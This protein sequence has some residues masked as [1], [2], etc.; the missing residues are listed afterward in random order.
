LSLLDH[1]ASYVVIGK[2]ALW[3]KV[4]EA[5]DGFRARFAKIVS[6][7][8]YEES[9]EMAEAAAQRYGV[10]VSR[11]LLR[12]PSRD[13]PMLVG[14][15]L[16]GG[17]TLIPP[18]AVWLSDSKVGLPCGPYDVW[19]WRGLDPAIKAARRK[20]RYERAIEG[21]PTWGRV[22]MRLKHGLVDGIPRTI[23]QTAVESGLPIAR[24]ETLTRALLGQ[25]HDQT[26]LE[27]P[28]GCTLLAVY[29]SG[30]LFVRPPFSV[31]VFR[32]LSTQGRRTPNWLTY[33]GTEGRCP[34]V[35]GDDVAGKE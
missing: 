24:V 13:T 35:D 22:A 14:G 6:L 19:R 15:P 27:H 16:R 3:G 18:D 2:V 17:P 29:R 31:P 1:D 34:L 32:L 10:P 4:I 23:E 5:T 12:G 33:E 11:S 26:P 8:P 25:L 21:L 30:G 7:A 20:A 28:E 9:L